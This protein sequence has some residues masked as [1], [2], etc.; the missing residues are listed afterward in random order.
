MTLTT[1]YDAVDPAGIPGRPGGVFAYGNGQY[2]WPS[3]AISFYRV[4]RIPVRLIDVNASD[5]G[6]CDVLDVERFDATPAQAHGW[7]TARHAAGKTATI[8]ANLAT[9]PAV[10]EACHGK[11]YHLW[12]ARWDGRG[13]LETLSNLPA[14]VVIGG[15]QYASHPRYDV[16]VMSA[17]WVKATA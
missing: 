15:H 8:Y 10:L 5:P 9:V 6:G 3:G 12:L 11:S 13:Q 17:E 2:A 14:G 7:I 1:F 4:A 16:S